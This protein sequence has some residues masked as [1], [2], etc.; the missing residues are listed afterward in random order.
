MLITF[1]DSYNVLTSV[2]GKGAFLKQALNDTVVRES[3]R[4]HLNKIC[5]GVLD[6][7]IT[8]SYAIKKLCPKNPKLPVRIILKIGLYSI[9]YLKNP[10][11]AVTDTCV[12]LA[13]K[14]GKGGTA[15]FINAVLRGYLRNGVNLEEK[16]VKGLSIKYSYPEFLIEKLIDNYGAK[17]TEDILKYDNENTF[18]RFNKGV[19]GL[20]FLQENKIDYQKTPFEDTFLVKNYKMDEHFKKGVYTFQSIGSVAICNVINKGDRLLDCCSAP[21]GKSVYLADKFNT[22]VATEYHPHRCELIKSYAKRMNKQNIEVINADSTVYDKKFDSF[23]DVV[24]CDA[25]CSGTGVIKDNPDIKLNRTESSVLELCKTQTAL[26]NNVCKYVKV[27]G[28]LIYSTCSILKE[29]NDLV[30]KEF[31]IKNNNF[32]VEKIDSPLNNFKTEYGLS[33]LPHVSLGAGFF[34]CKLKRVE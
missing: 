31:L 26:L 24:L 25:P 11:Y 1:Y 2:Y 16:G 33:F 5:Y 20:A 32:K 29:E 10:P 6:K 21:G 27:G 19:D 7:D 15:G 18:I 8:L 3:S 28:E 13:K 4:S 30:I 9:I 14:L 23:F 17:I 12:E 34:V 22:V